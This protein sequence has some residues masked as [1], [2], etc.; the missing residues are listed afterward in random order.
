MI[1]L[2]IA[3][4]E[5]AA[6]FGLKSL[7]ESFDLEI[8]VV[9]LAEDGLQALALAKKLLPEIFLIDINM[10][11]LSGLDL[12]E[13]L[14][15]ILP[16]SQMIIISGYGEFGYAQRAV[17]LNVFRYL[18]KPVNHAE[19]LHALTRAVEE[20]HSRLWELNQLGNGEIHIS[21]TV[22]LATQALRYIDTNY[23]DAE[24]TLSSVS[25]L[26]NV[27]N[28]HLSRMLK[29]QTGKSFPNYLTDLRMEQATRL[30][31]DK[32]ARMVYEVA[33]MVGYASQHYFCRV[34][35]EYT[36]MSPSEYRETMRVKER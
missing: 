36:G 18:L 7:V 9:G 21:S 19:L 20:H 34:F 4:D 3:D 16:D 11:G 26:L 15:A 10:P 24:I 27:S 30:L 31:R 22:E 5:N 1:K 8:S 29:Q 17:E 28:S 32:N 23:R 2:L 14:K 25:A 13:S 35:K 12:I 6:R 33:G